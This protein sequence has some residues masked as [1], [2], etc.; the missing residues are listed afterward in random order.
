MLNN[1]FQK[2][3]S[4][5]IISFCL[6]GILIG[7]GIVSDK[8]I[9]TAYAS[10]SHSESCY[11]EY[12]GAG[13]EKHSH[14][15]SCY[16][17][18]SELVTCGYYT[19]YHEGNSGCGA[20][21]TENGE[22]IISYTDGKCPKCEKKT[23]TQIRY[24]LKCSAKRNT[25]HDTEEY[26]TRKCS[27]CGWEA[28]SK[29][30]HYYC[31]YGAYDEY[32]TCNGDNCDEEGSYNSAH[33]Y[34][35]KN[36]YI[37]CGKAEGTYYNK[38]TKVE[39][40]CICSSIA[41]SY[42]PNIANAS[43]ATYNSS[44]GAYV[45]NSTFDA[46]ILNYATVTYKDGHTAQ[47]Q[48][49]TLY[50]NGQQTNASEILKN[51]NT[52][53]TVT[54]KA[55]NSHSSSSSF[56]IYVN[57]YFALETEADAAEGGTVSVSGMTNS[58]GAFLCTST[59]A[60]TVNINPGYEIEEWY[61][62]NVNS[63]ETT[64]L[65]S[66]KTVSFVMPAYNAKL[67]C[68]ITPKDYTFTFVTNVE[69]ICDDIT[70]AYG[71]YFTELP[72]L[73]KE[74]Y[75]FT[76][77]YTD[78]E[79]RVKNNT[80]FDFVP[81][82]ELVTLTAKWVERIYQIDVNYDGEIGKIPIAERP[83]YTLIGW[84]I[85]KD[86]ELVKEIDLLK[87][88]SFANETN[89]ELVETTIVKITESGTV[90][91]KW[92]PNKTTIMFDA[93]GGTFADGTTTAEKTVYYDNQI[94]NLPTPN[95]ENYKFVKWAYSTENTLAMVHNKTVWD[96]TD[97]TVTLYAV[98]SNE[99][100]TKN[101]NVTVYANYPNESESTIIHSFS[102][103]EN[104]P[105]TELENIKSKIE[106]DKGSDY[107]NKHNLSEYFYVN[108]DGSGM[109]IIDNL[110]L[111]TSETNELILYCAWSHTIS[112]NN[113]LSEALGSTPSDI[114]YGNSFYV[115]DC[116]FYKTG[117]T[118]TSWN[119][120][121]DGTGIDYYVGTKITLDTLENTTL[122]ARWEK[123]AYT[124]SLNAR[125]GRFDLSAVNPIS[126]MQGYDLADKN[127][128]ISLK[129][130]DLLPNSVNTPNKLG[131]TFEGY[132]TGINGTG[133]QVFDAAGNYCLEDTNISDLP[134]TAESEV[135]LGN[136]PSSDGNYNYQGN[137]ISII[138]LNTLYAYWEYNGTYSDYPEAVQQQKPEDEQDNEKV[139]STKAYVSGLLSDDYYNPYENIPSTEDISANITITEYKV[140]YTY[141]ASG[142][143]EKEE[144]SYVVKSD[145][146]NTIFYYQVYNPETEELVFKKAVYDTDYVINKY[147]QHKII[148]D[149]AIMIPDAIN[150]YSS[151][152]ENEIFTKKLTSDISDVEF[153]VKSY[154]NYNTY[155][156]GNV[157]IT[158]YSD[159][160][161][162]ASNQIDID[163]TNYNN[164]KNIFFIATDTNGA[165]VDFTEPASFNGND[166]D[167]LIDIILNNIAVSR[168][169]GI[170]DTI[171]VSTDVK[172]KEISIENEVPINQEAKNGTYKV[173]YEVLYD[174]AS[175]I[176]FAGGTSS[177]LEVDD[178]GE[179][180]V[181][182]DFLRIFTPIATNLEK[183]IIG[184]KTEGVITSFS[185]NSNFESQSFTYT[186]YWGSF[187]ESASKKLLLYKYADGTIGYAIY[188]PFNVWC[189]A[190]DENGERTF[191]YYKA[192]S[193]IRWNESEDAKTF[194][195]A[196]SLNEQM[197]N[198]SKTAIS[199][200]TAVNATYN[201]NPLEL[202]NGKWIWS[203]VKRLKNNTI[204]D[205][206]TQYVAYD[207][208]QITANSV[209]D[210]KLV[211]DST[212]TQLKTG[213]IG[214]YLLGDEL[215]Y[216][217]DTAGAFYDDN[218]SIEITPH[219]SLLTEDLEIVTDPVNFYTGL[220]YSLSEG[221][222]KHVVNFKNHSE[223]TNKHSIIS[224]SL[225][226]H[227]NDVV[228][229]K[230]IS[231]SKELLKTSDF[232]QEYTYDKIVL[233]SASRFVRDLASL[234][235]YRQDSWF[236]EDY[237]AVSVDKNN[238]YI[239]DMVQK[240]NVRWCG[241][242]TLPQ[243]ITVIKDNLYS[244]FCS[245]CN[246]ACFKYNQTATCSNC[247]AK[248]IQLKKFL[249]DDGENENYLYDGQ[250]LPFTEKS[251]YVELTFDIL[252]TDSL[253]IVTEIEN[254]PITDTTGTTQRVIY[255]LGTSK[256]DRYTV[257]VY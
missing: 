33:Q 226:Q 122:Y 120:K 213:D 141:E 180:C 80:I 54:I 218:C 216:Y 114:I 256:A 86:G 198:T 87:N 39:A 6:S 97:E 229:D 77:W 144:V 43:G 223:N 83:G 36:T 142:G 119:T 8:D 106:L 186:G 155:E 238:D 214:Y 10:H 215:R 197:S 193:P 250:I 158:V 135:L 75:V 96:K 47:N 110:T 231:L 99:S 3:L 195:V 228:S 81:S 93:N 140:E 203:C 239:D 118:F 212:T 66:E 185:V 206:N 233:N 78:D 7:C 46:N 175:Q 23:V 176:N 139:K 115:R 44:K 138:N 37:A 172:T 72:T 124:F 131:Y 241:A 167:E 25:N 65:S 1:C 249:L 169:D 143:T 230:E 196:N 132:Y 149:I 242:F 201:R 217:I 150:I 134:I 88:E 113:N 182:G 257:I 31:H 71:E 21:M 147:L 111:A 251:G 45:V 202:L 170:S 76:G 51:Y 154:D 188:F 171:T 224:Y 253:G 254:I 247:G 4:R 199:M 104:E 28:T 130:G 221:Y 13:V 57:G 62:Y 126:F 17:T 153:T 125:G 18:D 85:I 190:L 181:D 63:G 232:T 164:N 90:Y 15:D 246:K 133:T 35:K 92:Q 177:G 91:T 152:L 79:I 95:K 56:K 148:G 102:V 208:A 52:V 9:E 64:S 40:K 27:S 22:T 210:A 245:E 32:Y 26:Q 117:Y 107:L 123:T 69:Q 161:G 112:Y 183:I 165:P 157:K 137:F 127:K 204:S 234:S 55:G 225:L 82:S 220:N 219:Y 16:K 74:G 58:E 179:R 222:T 12:Y 109:G 200:V 34:Y 243:N 191:K 67:V 227:L 29:E 162:V 151:A 30:D 159:H 61:L 70:L 187:K 53:Q 116:G 38:N 14:T 211:L 105:L 129:Y 59:V 163:L 60:A 168:Q 5:I 174:V 166:V 252:V 103:K 184:L 101:I 84:G 178:A 194:Y 173:T 136:L 49:C 94:G 156:Y 237:G 19:E 68:K 50:V 244:G 20:E 108:A 236:F 192:G 48:S 128:T 24:T 235:W 160:M 121:E 189:Y 2:T 89:G 100:T 207:E 42:T 255:K 240:A 209:V 98:Y 145:S 73:S 146:N 11:E 248:L 205:N 41:T